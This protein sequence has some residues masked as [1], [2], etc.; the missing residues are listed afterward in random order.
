MLT[1]SHCKTHAA[2]LFKQ[3][4]LLNVYDINT[5]QIA[6]FVYKSKNSLLPHCFA[7]FFESNDT[8]HDYN[9]RNNR[10]IK[11]HQSTT[12][13]RFLVINVT[14]LESGMTLTYL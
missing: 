3:M 12:S 5:L 8:V 13:V 11:L 4:N 2:P 6:C 10:N 14:N 9:Q 1:N 7:N